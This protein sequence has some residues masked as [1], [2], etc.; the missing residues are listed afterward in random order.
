MITRHL[1]EYLRAAARTMPVISLTG[2]RQSGKTTLV[3]EAFP[4]HAYANLEHLPTRQYAREN[5]VGFLEQYP[6]GLI[7]DEAQY[8]PELFSYI[9]V[10]VDKTRRN[11]DYILTG[12]QNFLLMENITQSLA[13][14][15]AVF[16]L[17]PFSA[18]ELADTEYQLRNPFEYIVKGFYPRVYDQQTPPGVFYPS[19]LLTYLERDVRLL[20]NIGDLATFER[21]IRLCAGHIGQVF[22]QSSLANDTGLSQPTVKSW[23]SVLET[24]FVAF[25]LPPYFRN[26]NKRLLKTPKLYFYDTGLACSLLGIRSAAELEN[27]FMRSALFENFIVVECMKQFLNRGLRIPC[28]YWRDSTG[29][30][31]DLLV[32]QAGRL[33]PIEIKSSQTLKSDFFKNLEFFQKLSD[34]PPEQS[35]LVYAGTENQN[36]LRGFAR[37]WEQLPVFD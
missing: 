32:E 1:S 11:G 37:G 23:L 35:Y 22:N 17:L 21:F 27:H 6:N 20:K 4:E 13:G 30:E 33:Y 5:P 12:S 16:N 36:R 34:T 26:F 9:Q 25:L 29:N 7:V 18:R 3:R 14:R 24:S 31:I 8:V 2:P 10:Q 28:Y 15:V 19:Y